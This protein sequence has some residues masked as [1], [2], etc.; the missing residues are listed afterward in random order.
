MIRPEFITTNQRS[1][2]EKQMQTATFSLG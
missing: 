2:V 1:L